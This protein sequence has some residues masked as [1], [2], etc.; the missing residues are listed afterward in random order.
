M[1]GSALSLREPAGSVG[2]GG[3]SPDLTLNGGAACAGEAQASAIA[4]ATPARH[5][6][7]TAY[8]TAYT[9]D[10][11]QPTPVPPQ[12]ASFYPAYRIFLARTRLSGRTTHSRDARRAGQARTGSGARTG[13]ELVCLAIAQAGG[14]RPPVG[15]RAASAQ[16]S[17]RAA[18]D[19]A[20]LRSRPVEGGPVPVAAVPDG[21]R[22]RSTDGHATA[23]STAALSSGG[24][25]GGGGEGG[26]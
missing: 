22:P 11:T 16:G 14:G 8:C 5:R 21:G 20:A 23:G 10:A 6:F 4:H 25:G 26:P 13:G 19:L 2:A 1:P 24:G 17:S 9:P 12:S 15:L 18:P 3:K 7:I